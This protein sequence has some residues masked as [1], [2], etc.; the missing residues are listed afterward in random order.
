MAVGSTPPMTGLAGQDDV[1]VEIAHTVE[2]AQT[3]FNRALDQNRYLRNEIVQMQ[4]RHDVEMPQMRVDMRQAQQDVRQ[5]QTTT[6]HN[7]YNTRLDL[8][9]VK[10]MSPSI[11]Y[12]LN[13]DGPL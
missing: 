12:G 10:S 2:Y 1:S 3:I 11:L 6:N 13:S 7:N 5:A 9:D 8:V 4:A